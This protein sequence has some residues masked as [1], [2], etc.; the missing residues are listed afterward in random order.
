MFIDGFGISGFRSFGQDVQRIGP[1]K[2][3][4]LFIGQN[5]SGKSNILLF[6]K[7]HYASALKCEGIKLQDVDRHIGCDL[8]QPVIEFGLKIGS[9]NYDDILKLLE[10]RS[11]NREFY[12]TNIEKIFKSKTLTEEGDLAWFSYSN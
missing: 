11:A 10:K 3:I 12:K 1:L 8:G 5:N 7:H 6:L 9:A 2:K 4:N